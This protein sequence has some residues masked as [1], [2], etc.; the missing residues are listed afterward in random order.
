MKLAN[1]KHQPDLPSFALHRFFGATVTA[2]LALTLLTGP[3]NAGNWIYLTCEAPISGDITIEDMG[4]ESI[5]DELAPLADPNGYLPPGSYNASLVFSYHEA[6]LST[7]SHSG[8]GVVELAGLTVVRPVAKSSP[9]FWE[10]M[11][12]G[13]VLE[14]KFRFI[15]EREIDSGP[16][17]PYRIITI[18]SAV[19]TKIEPR[20][21][22]QLEAPGM[23]RS[24]LE[25]ITFTFGEIR[26]ESR[27]G[28]PNYT[29]IVG[30]GP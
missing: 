17:T 16:N 14:C 9:R 10:A 13:H 4:V 1:T 12:K 29:Y 2:G 15:R 11:V 20:A 30:E 8:P 26:W 24:H 19:V 28:D 22:A 21:V 7:A 27:D 25:A 18:K 23:G 6:G 5:G 3:A